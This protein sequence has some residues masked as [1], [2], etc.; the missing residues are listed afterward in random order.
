VSFA[1]SDQ[2]PV[3]FP[4]RSLFGRAPGARLY[5]LLLWAELSRGRSGSEDL[6]RLTELVAGGRLQCSVDLESSWREA[7]EAIEALVDRRIAGK[8]VLRI[9]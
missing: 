7:P 9:D 4:T 2:S 5:G 8:A 1:S 6:R 3:Q